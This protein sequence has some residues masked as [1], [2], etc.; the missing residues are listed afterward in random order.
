M[1]LDQSFCTSPLFAY[2]SG[3]AVLSKTVLWINILMTVK[4]LSAIVITDR[5][6]CYFYYRNRG[7]SQ[8]MSVLLAEFSCSSCTLMGTGTCLKRRLVSCCI[9]WCALCG[10]LTLHIFM[11]CVLWYTFK[12]LPFHTAYCLWG[13]FCPVCLEQSWCPLPVLRKPCEFVMWLITSDS[14]HLWAIWC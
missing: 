7:C 8:G 12:G 1:T 2:E 13:I 10:H 6:W 9:A 3:V 4:C 11:K 14:W 5:Y